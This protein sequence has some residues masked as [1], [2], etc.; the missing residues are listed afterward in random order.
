MKRA[1][2]VCVIAAFGVMV[3]VAIPSA[4]ERDAL[5][6]LR[7]PRLDATESPTFPSREARVPADRAE[8]AIGE[9]IVDLPPIVIEATV[10]RR[11]TQPQV[12]APQTDAFGA[13][14]CDAWRSL[15]M[16]SGSVRACE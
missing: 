9:R 13:M 12:S 10:S 15:A 14:H 4:S 2:Y 5:Q 1:L 7:S 3:S 8:A 16:G 11:A 6:E